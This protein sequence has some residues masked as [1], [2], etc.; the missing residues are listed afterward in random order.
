MATQSHNNYTITNVTY[1]VAGGSNVYTSHPTAVLT[2]TPD[3]GYSVTA[4]DFSWAN[5]TLANVNTVVF[6]Q[7][8]AN[9]ICTVTFDN[10]F[11]MPTSN[12]T[13]SLCING[14]A[15][16]QRLSLR[17]YYQATGSS[18]NMSIVQD[19][20]VP[21]EIS[22]E[23]AGVEGY[24]VLV[25]EKTYTASSGYYFNGSFNISYTGD[26]MVVEN[27]NCIETETL[28]SSGR[29]TSI[30]IKFYYT[31]PNNS[32]IN[33]K[34]VVEIP[35]TKQIKV[36]PVK[37]FSYSML[38]TDASPDGDY[39]VMRVFGTPTATFTLASNNGSILS[40][41]TYDTS[42]GDLLVYTTTPTLT[43]PASGFFDIN[44]NLPTVTSN[45]V[46]C[47]TLGGGNLVSPF[48]QSNPVCIYQYVNTSLTFTASGTNMS[49]GSTSYVRTYPA[50]SQPSP[51]TDGYNNTLIFSVSG[52]SGQA[53]SLVSNPDV[54]N[55]W[56]NYPNILKTI[57]STV[58]NAN[59]IALNNVTNLV[60]G[61]ELAQ[62]DNFI[63]PA[64]KI[65]NISGNNITI[66]GAAITISSLTNFPDLSFNG[67]QKSELF[68]PAEVIINDT[69]TEATVTSSGYISK[70]GDANVTFNLNLANLITVGSTNA[71]GK[72]TVSAGTRGGSF[73]YFD[74]ITGA[75]R[76]IVLNKGD[77]SFAICALASPAPSGSGTVTVVNNN[78]VCAKTAST[79]LD[80]ITW[81]IVYNP[82]L[83]AKAKS[84]EV[85]YIDCVTLEEETL[86]VGI[87]ATATTQCA[88][89][90]V[91]IS[92]DPGDG[93]ATITQTWN[94]SNPCT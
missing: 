38:T 30:N 70:Y 64:R 92:S 41:D 69:S 10:P 76:Q 87:G 67:R 86:N 39:R 32:V 2:I 6:T 65:T 82:G 94:G 35:A 68:L 36:V 37:I 29:L 73:I 75:K 5:T 60:V 19:C 8:G 59:I 74:C 22:Y 72:Y 43:I 90:Q 28:D 78:T 3:V 46:Y 4:E 7:D 25:I 83:N 34:I 33:D 11:T 89:R 56:S 23:V 45:A 81:S 26:E 85:T 52:D 66:D 57:Q 40:F 80:C 48:P 71:C 18:T 49:V 62:V 31:F 51:G 14:A 27:Y 84:V 13:L 21:Q 58:S 93:G 55:A 42:S 44:I 61:M 12:T 50:L 91:P 88:T 63:E 1:S 24:Q 17:G 20:P 9:V 15:I 53:L 54:D 77:I 16:R 79:Q 47:L